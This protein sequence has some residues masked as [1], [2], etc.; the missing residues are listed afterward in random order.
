MKDILFGIIISFIGLALC[1]I[2]EDSFPDGPKKGVA[3]LCGVG[4]G[5]VGV[6]LTVYG[7]AQMFL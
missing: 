2:A 5:I 7:I 4:V 6:L 3:I 1:D